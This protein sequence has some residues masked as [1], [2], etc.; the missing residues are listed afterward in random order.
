MAQSKRTRLSPEE[1]RMQLLD[2]A[3]AI[4]LAKGLSSFT[5]D[6]LAREAGVSNPLVYKYFGDKDGLIDAVLRETFDEWSTLNAA[7]AT[8]SGAGPADALQR[9][10]RSAI[11]FVQARPV[12]RS[13]LLQDPQIVVRGHLDAL[14]PRIS[15]GTGGSASGSRT[16]RSSSHCSEIGS[17][18]SASI[19]W[20]PC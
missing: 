17:R 18:G 5:M 10:F 4:I 9:K 15:S 6:A 3:K 14:R 20:L 16:S 2:S 1:R 19:V 13:I 11:E 7:F 12:F 8:S